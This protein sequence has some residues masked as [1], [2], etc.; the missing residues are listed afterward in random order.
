MDN[1]IPILEF[2]IHNSSEA[3]NPP[4]KIGYLK[5]PCT[6]LNCGL[7]IKLNTFGSFSFP[8]VE[9]LYLISFLKSSFSENTLIS[10]SNSSH[11]SL[12]YF[13]SLILLYKYASPRVVLV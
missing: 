4:A 7:Y 12:L 6:L 5:Y 10:P 2:I 1:P 9:R 3:I 8:M 13:I 11:F